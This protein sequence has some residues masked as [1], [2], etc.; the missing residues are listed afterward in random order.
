[1]D[2]QE[3]KEFAGSVY[4]TEILEVQGIRVVKNCLGFWIR[5]V[6]LLIVNTKDGK[7][8]GKPFLTPEYSLSFAEIGQLCGG[9]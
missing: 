1:M 2:T 5:I 4:A 3:T 6:D 9:N 8:M 7:P